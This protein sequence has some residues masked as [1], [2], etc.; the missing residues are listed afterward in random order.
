VIAESTRWSLALAMTTIAS[1][2]T[3][4]AGLVGDVIGPLSSLAGFCL[5]VTMIIYWHKKTVQL[6]LENEAKRLD[7]LERVREKETRRATD[8]VESE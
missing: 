1:G 6:N 7:N 5:T 8:K 4:A 2:L 3:T